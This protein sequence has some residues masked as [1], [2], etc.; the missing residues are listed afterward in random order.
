MLDTDTAVD[1]ADWA[2][3]WE[4]QQ[5]FHIP[6]REQRFQLMLELVAELAGPSP[7]RILDLACGPGS[8][9]KR[10]LQRFPEATLVAL[11]ADPF[12]LAIGQQTLGDAGGRLH[13]AQADLR[14]ADWTTA[15]QDFAPFDAVLTSTALH[16]L[17]AGDLMRVY[18]SLG[19][20]IRPGGV[21]FNTEHLLLAP[22]KTRFGEAAQRVRQRLTSEG[23]AP[24]ESWDAWW[25]AARAEDGFA[26]LLQQRDEVFDEIHPHHHESLT[27]RF[28]EEALAIAG[29][30]EAAVVWRFL[31]DTIVGGMR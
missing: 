4:A 27:A 2:E 16:W 13:W 22:P 3:R 23:R 31:D 14:R 9:S 28:H 1:W 6:R 12:L 8:I 21:F 26:A 11:D 24:G 17:E 20:L 10:A 19:E 5:Q 7:R 15:V 25:D 29:F 18:R 30:A